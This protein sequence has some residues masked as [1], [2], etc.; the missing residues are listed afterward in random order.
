MKNIELY[1]RIQ[2]FLEI[3]YQRTHLDDL[4]IFLGTGCTL[5]FH[6]SD[7]NRIESVE[8]RHRYN[9]MQDLWFWEAWLKTIG[10]QQYVYLYEELNNDGEQWIAM[11]Q[12]LDVDCSKATDYMF[13]FIRELES[14]LRTDW[15]KLMSDI[16]TE[17]KTTMYEWKESEEICSQMPD[18]RETYLELFFK[19]EDMLY[20]YYCDTKDPNIKVLLVQ[21]HQQQPLLCWIEWLKSVVGSDNLYG[22]LHERNN[23]YGGISCIVHRFS[24][25][26][27]SHRHSFWEGLNMNEKLYLFSVY[28]D[29]QVSDDINSKL[30]LSY[31]KT[32]EKIAHIDMSTIVSRYSML[33]SEMNTN[34]P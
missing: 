32:M 23:L 29:F 16:I 3:Y 22:A 27:R 28:K 12:D 5:V 9:E 30:F 31:L 2:I 15:S 19:M 33:S 10:Y 11:T 20:Q 7:D 21:Y 25:C 26:V 8:Q 6:W 13:A 17:E 14:D 1:N 4:E 34:L 24:L 18:L